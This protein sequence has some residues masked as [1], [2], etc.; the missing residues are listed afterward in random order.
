MEIE[1]KLMLDSALS[2]FV[3]FFL[4]R[5]C[6]IWGAVCRRVVFVPTCALFMSLREQ[7]GL[8]FQETCLQR[9]IIMVSPFS[10]LFRLAFLH[11]YVHTVP[12]G[13][14]LISQ[15]SLH[16]VRALFSVMSV[17]FVLEGRIWNSEEDPP[18]HHDRDDA[19]PITFIF[20]S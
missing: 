12:V 15:V 7:D 19:D 4:D 10:V 1:S 17:T 14:T 3:S 11:L 5:V 8:V 20:Y 6:S 18:G 16:F 9:V 13:P 2:L